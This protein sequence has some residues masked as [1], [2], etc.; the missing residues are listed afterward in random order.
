MFVFFGSIKYYVFTKSVDSN[1]CAFWLAPITRNDSFA[2]HYFATG[3]KM[4]SRLETFSE[5]KIWAIFEAV[6]QINTKKA[7]NVGLTVFTGTQKIVFMLNLQQ[8]RKNALDKVPE[9]PTNWLFLIYKKFPFFS[10]I[11]LIW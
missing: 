3:A 1:F 2:I 8:N 5:D 4:A 10:F 9:N 11:Q 7:T 6:I